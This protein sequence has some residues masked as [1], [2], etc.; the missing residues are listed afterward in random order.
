[1]IPDVLRLVVDK[2]FFIDDKFL[3]YFWIICCCCVC[4][5]CLLF[6]YLN[7]QE[8]SSQHETKPHFRF[9]STFSKP[10]IYTLPLR[11]QSP[12]TCEWT[13]SFSRFDQSGDRVWDA[14]FLWAKR[15]N[16]PKILCPKD[17]EERTSE[18][19]LAA[20]DRIWKSNKGKHD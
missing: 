1:M 7:G 13:C 8:K 3:L 19:G 2:N 9:V 4:R 11:K 18:V 16:R 10:T 15:C 17:G 20:G 5:R 14:K 12:S 6:C